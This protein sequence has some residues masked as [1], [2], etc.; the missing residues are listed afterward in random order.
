MILSAKDIG[1]LVDHTVWQRGKVVDVAAPYAFVHF[2]SLEDTEQGPL[3]KVQATIEHLTRSS[4]QSDPVF[5]AIPS[6]LSPAKAKAGAKRKSAKA[7]KA[8]KAAKAAAE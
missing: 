1:T 6:A 2:P 8:V 3:R 4:V 5:D 7:A